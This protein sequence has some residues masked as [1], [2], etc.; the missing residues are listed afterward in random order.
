M[1]FCSFSSSYFLILSFL[2]SLFYLRHLPFEFT[3]SS[4][5]IPCSILSLPF[6]LSFLPASPLPFL[7]HLF[8]RLFPP[9]YT[10]PFPIS[11]HL[12]SSVVSLPFFSPLSLVLSLSSL[13]ISL[14]YVFSLNI[15]PPLQAS[16]SFLFCLFH[17]TLT[18]VFLE[19][20]PFRSFSLLP[21]V[22]PPPTP[23]PSPSPPPSHP[24]HFLFPPHSI[25]H[26]V[27][28]LYAFSPSS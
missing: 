18:A 7:L 9:Y 8:V 14:P 6:I 16:L 24:P 17:P 12:Y 20:S 28:A 10:Q 22:P 2:R 4:S 19:V 26:P 15:S 11:C 21:A 27:A 23:L 1:C 3:S 5:S 25:C 13:L